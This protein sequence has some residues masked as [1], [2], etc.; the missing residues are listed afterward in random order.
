MVVFISAG[1]SNAKK[2]EHPFAR[3]HLYLNYGLLGLAT[4][5][6]KTGLASRVF[7]GDFSKPTDFMA[8]RDLRAV[9]MNTDFPVFLSLPSGKAVPWA[10]E[11][12]R[13]VKELRKDVKVVIGGRWV[14]RED[15][16]WLRP[17]LGGGDLFVFGTAERRIVDLLRP[18]NWNSVAYTDR[19]F[20]GSCPELP[21]P[22]LPDLD[23]TLL[24]G[25]PEYTASLEVSRGCGMGC[26]FCLERDVPLQTLRTPAN[27]VENLDRYAQFFGADITPYFECSFFR[28]S[29][30]WINELAK[31]YKAEGL[32]LR[33]RTESRVDTLTPS[34][35]EC[36]AAGGMKVIDLGLESASARQLL[37]MRKT[38]RPT[39]Y[40]RKADELLRACH[41]NGIWT[42]VNVL[43]YAGETEGTL[44]ETLE[45]IES[46]RAWV[47]G[48]SVNPVVVYRDGTSA[49]YCLRSLRELGARPVADGSLE[50]L[51]YADLH[52]SKD[53][54]WANSLERCLKI[55]QSFMNARDYFDLKSFSY[56]PR[57]LTWQGFQEIVAQTPEQILPFRVI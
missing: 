37:A 51:G 21:L 52:L 34:Q 2:S 25:Y 44:N 28:P 19:T 49:D 15:V 50:T 18:E 53:F 4:I 23:Y 47:K 55:G 12:L 3:L 56:F 27:V 26:S 33:W 7:H 11:F 40:L 9:L 48:V 43:L 30:N 16:S 38:T 20:P 24:A 1:L 32:E 22:D 13:L 17:A 42:K 36:L 31:R 39:V 54:D 46:R 6:Y 10:A 5:V 14:L 29:A 41:E 45:W 57:S 35:V 8:R